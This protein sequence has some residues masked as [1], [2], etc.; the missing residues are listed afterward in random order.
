MAYVYNLITPDT[1]L[2][3]SLTVPFQ[4]VLF[5]GNDEEVNLVISAVPPISQMGAVLEIQYQTW[6]YT[7]NAWV[8]QTTVSSLA[9]AATTTIPL[10][11]EGQVASQL[12]LTYTNTPAAT[13]VASGSNGGEIS[14]IA[15]WSAPSAGVLDV[16]SSASFPS[17]GTVHVAASGSTTAVVTY[18]GKGTGTLTGCAYVSGSATGTVA[19]GG[20]VTLADANGNFTVS[21]TQTG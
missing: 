21:I 11:A 16:A 2:S 15:S 1:N 17:S 3:S 19:T 9:T 8:N 18:T 10:A 7:T 12:I 20:A 13:T 14:A 6:D 4:G 5:A